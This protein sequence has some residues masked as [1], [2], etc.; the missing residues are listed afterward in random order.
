[1]DNKNLDRVLDNQ[2]DLINKLKEE[3]KKLLLNRQRFEESNKILWDNDYSV[4]C[5]IDP[6]VVIEVENVPPNGLLGYSKRQFINNTFNWTK[7]GMFKFDE[8]KRIDTEHRKRS[9]LAMNLGLNHFDIRLT[10]KFIQKNHSYI[11]GHY[12]SFY[13]M[14]KNEVK[15]YVKFLPPVDK[16][17]KN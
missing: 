7:G 13:D 16:T 4:V 10:V 5:S 12:V 15:M 6:L 9:D 11:L 3:N 1:M 17:I 14:I 8:I 2:N